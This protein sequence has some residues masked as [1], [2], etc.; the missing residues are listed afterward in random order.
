M[1]D[2]IS[3]S[4]VGAETDE[5]LSLFDMEQSADLVT[6]TISLK[7]I[8]N[9]NNFVCIDFGKVM[10]FNIPVTQHFVIDG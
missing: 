9:L 2:P 4:D 7:H 1:D 8:D 6:V 3:W 5:C 10:S